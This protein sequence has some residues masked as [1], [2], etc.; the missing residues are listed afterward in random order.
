MPTIRA[1]IGPVAVTVVVLAPSPL[2]SGPHDDR[3]PA[4]LYGR[5]TTDLT[6]NGVTVAV[7]LAGDRLNAALQGGARRRRRRRPRAELMRPLRR[8][9]PAGW[10]FPGGRITGLLPR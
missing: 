10:A 5:L 4:E 7:D 1:G 6:A 8:S 9:P 3:V 2:L